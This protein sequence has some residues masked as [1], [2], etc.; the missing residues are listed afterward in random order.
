MGDG[1]L[2]FCTGNG[3]VCVFV[4]ARETCTHRLYMPVCVTTLN[5]HD[6]CLTVDNVGASILT[7]YIN[8][9]ARFLNTS[10]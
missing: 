1:V 4:V 7:D 3:S 5:K 6:E 2:F 9:T 8:G 10:P